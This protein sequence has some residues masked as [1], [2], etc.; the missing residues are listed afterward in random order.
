MPASR[1]FA[2]AAALLGLAV[3]LAAQG[4]TLRASVVSG[5][6][7]AHFGGVWAA[8]SGDGRYVAFASDS[9]DLAPL[10]TN[11]ERDTFVH[12]CLTGLTERVSV[13]DAGIG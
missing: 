2:L 5:G 6:G 3:P 4:R 12:D 9:D 10:D 13:N 7:E 1:S 8:L 11:F